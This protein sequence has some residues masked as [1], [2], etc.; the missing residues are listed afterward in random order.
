[1]NNFKYYLTLLLIIL[2]IILLITYNSDLLQNFNFLDLKN[3]I[4]ID[5]EKTRELIQVPV[6]K[7]QPIKQ[8]IQ[9]LAQQQIPVPELAQTYLIHNENKYTDDNNIN[10]FFID[11]KIDSDLENS[12]DKKYFLNSEEYQITE[13]TRDAIVNALQN[14]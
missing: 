10:E 11:N 9:Q 2:I 13:N 5:F 7:Q 1:M 8:P 14:I 12:I 6:Q 4:N 3:I